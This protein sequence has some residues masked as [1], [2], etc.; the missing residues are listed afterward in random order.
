MSVFMKTEEKTPRLTFNKSERLKSR[1]L[2]QSLFSENQNI[3]IYP[4]KLVWTSQPNNN[5]LLLKMG[6]SATK[7]L[8]R[9]AV[10]RNLIKRRMRECIRLNKTILTSQLSEKN[11]TLSFMLIYIGKDIVTYNEFDTKIKQMLTRLGKKCI[12]QS[13]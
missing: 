7:R 9:L 3:K 13:K 5:K 8:F 10:T 4:F 2:I 11:I 12:A 1:K 6:V